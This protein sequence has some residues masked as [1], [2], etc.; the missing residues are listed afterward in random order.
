MRNGCSLVELIVALLLLQVGVLAVSGMVLLAQRQM[1]LAELSA[2]G[3]L[4]AQWVADSLLA[5]GGGLPTE[6]GIQHFPWGEVRFFPGDLGLG[7]VRMIATRHGGSDT[8]AVIRR[9]SP[10]AGS[11]PPGVGLEEG[12]DVR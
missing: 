12:E 5:R 6:E 3:V 11:L 4:E 2:R 8:L 7:G 10:M 9:W 1:A